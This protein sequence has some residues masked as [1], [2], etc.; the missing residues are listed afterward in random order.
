MAKKIEIENSYDIL[1]NKTKDKNDFSFI[2]ELNDDPAKA[3][4]RVRR[5]LLQNPREKER[6]AQFYTDLAED[7]NANAQFE[8]ANFYLEGI[9][10]PQDEAKAKEWLKKAAKQGH[11]EAIE[12]LDYKDKNPIVITEQRMLPSTEITCEKCGTIIKLKKPLIIHGHALYVCPKCDVYHEY[13]YIEPQ[14]DGGPDE[15]A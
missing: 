15:W 7:G 9:G 14:M 4:E 13:V 10:V 12:L 2:N 6:V 1:Q 3:G 5:M 11:E 8:L